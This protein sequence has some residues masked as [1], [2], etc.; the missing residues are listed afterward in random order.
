MNAART[1]PAL[2]SMSVR[3]AGLGD[4]E[5][6]FD[7]HVDAVNGQCGSHNSREQLDGWFEGRSSADYTKAIE[8]GGVWIAHLGGVAVGFVE[9]FTRTISMLYVRSACAGGGVGGRLLRF[10]VEH[11][12][13]T[14][15][16]IELEALLDAVGFYERHGFTRT[17]DSRLQRPCGLVLP[18][19]RME[20]RP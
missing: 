11:M 7:I 18:T 8:V 15:D 5:T 12:R 14:T 16:R 3:R 4:R 19:V 9:F 20:R 2:A 1:G 10:A 17:G 6:I 13:E